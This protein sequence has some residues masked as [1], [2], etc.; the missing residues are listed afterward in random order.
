MNWPNEMQG[1][2]LLAAWCN[3]LRRMCIQENIIEGTD[4]KIERVAGG[5]ILKIRTG[6]GTA[7]PGGRQGPFQIDSVQ[8]EYLTCYPYDPVKG[9]RTSTTPV[10]IAKEDKHQNSLNTETIF[11][12]VHNYTYQAGTAPPGGL[13]A[14]DANNVFRTDSYG[15]NVE[16]QRIIPPWVCG[17]SGELVWAQEATTG[18]EDADGNSVGLQIAGRSCQW[19]VV[20]T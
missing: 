9:E 6:G 17:V 18:V 1:T 13:S 10:Y 11:G 8:D 2:S 16:Y 7:V 19:G 20:Q 12:V 5:K 14:A 15:G 4:Y 3:R